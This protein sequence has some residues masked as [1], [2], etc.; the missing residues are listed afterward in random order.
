VSAAKLWP[1]AM[2]AVLALT[3]VA[4]VAVLRLAHDPDAAIVEP[5]AYPRAVAWDSTAAR[6]DASAALGW[7]ALA[8][9]D[10]I[11][12]GRA[13]LRV[14]LRDRDGRSVEGARASVEAVHNR[15]RLRPRASLLPAGEGT[16][17]GALPLARDGM[18]EL[19]VVAVRGAEIFTTSLRV[20]AV[21]G[22][23]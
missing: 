1:A 16:Y 14:R 3:V 7:T 10:P 23:P 21:R 22:T 13:G 19:R 8:T 18:W 5:D 9:L 15:E 12:D 2:V 20:D 17:A 11:A 4:N 6:R